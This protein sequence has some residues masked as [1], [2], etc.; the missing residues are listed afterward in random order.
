MQ[1][2]LEAGG[3][4]NYSRN[5][6]VT[7]PPDT[8]S[9]PIAPPPATGYS[10]STVRAGSSGSGAGAAASIPPSS[11]DSSYNIPPPPQYQPP[12]MPGPVAPIALPKHAEM[13]PAMEKAASDAAYASAKDRIGLTGRASLD[14]LHEEMGARNISGSGIEGAETANLISGMQGELGSTARQQ[15]QGDLARMQAVA[16]MVY[17]TESGAATANAGN[18]VAQ[19]GQDL[20][21]LTSQS[22]TRYS[23][24]LT[25][26]GQTLGAESDLVSQRR[27][28]VQALAALRQGGAIY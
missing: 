20:G 1:Q 2:V 22:A 16:D 7:N 21:S 19:R 5:P 11:L 23:G 8:Y 12:Q 26:R 4:Y 17:G 25:A 24:E 18:Q 15:S 14:A 9:L 13:D 6:G 28:S 3:T 10:G 27:A